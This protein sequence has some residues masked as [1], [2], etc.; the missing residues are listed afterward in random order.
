LAIFDCRSTGNGNEATRQQ[1][2][3][4][5]MK[6]KN[7]KSITAMILVVVA[8]LFGFANAGGGGTQFGDWLGFEG[9]ANSVHVEIAELTDE[10][11]GLNIRSA[12]PEGTFVV[13]DSGYP[14][15][16]MRSIQADKV[17]VMFTF[18]DAMTGRGAREFIFSTRA[19]GGTPQV[20]CWT[21]FEQ[22]GNF[23]RDFQI[24][25]GNKNYVNAGFTPES[26]ARWSA[27]IAKNCWV[28]DVAV[29]R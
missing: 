15:F 17:G 13:G 9:W 10:G 23:D 16:G 2:K 8:G 29:R 5:N 3:E 26:D 25:R 27:C 18:T 24:A 4:A 21:D 1:G 14:E 22:I 11:V 19:N 6:L 28:D 12:D 20:F 7:W